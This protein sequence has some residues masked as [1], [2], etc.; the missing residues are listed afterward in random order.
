[1][2]TYNPACVR[3]DKQVGMSSVEHMVKGSSADSLSFH[4]FF[5]KADTLI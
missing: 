3:W 5:F 2:K 1:M 4:K